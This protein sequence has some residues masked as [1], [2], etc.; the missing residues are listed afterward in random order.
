MVS[1]SYPGSLARNSQLSSLRGPAFAFPPPVPDAEAPGIPINSPTLASGVTSSFLS[2]SRR[3]KRPWLSV[4]PSVRNV[5]LHALSMAADSLGGM[6]STST[7][8][9]R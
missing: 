3:L 2:P 9:Y 4:Y 8:P 1:D 5:P 6:P 7:R